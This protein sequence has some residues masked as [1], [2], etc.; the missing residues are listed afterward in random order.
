M[1][2]GMVPSTEPWGTP[3]WIKNGWDTQPS[4]VT[5]SYLRALKATSNND[6]S[7]F[8]TIYLRSV[9]KMQRCLVSQRGVAC[10]FVICSSRQP[11]VVFCH[12]HQACVTT[13]L[14][15]HLWWR[16]PLDLVR[17][18]DNYTY[19]HTHMH[20]YTRTHTDIRTYIHTNVYAYACIYI[21]IDINT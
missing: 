20:P 9:F 13:L 12:H 1:I 14:W 16:F 7:Y 15:R 3:G 4:I 10:M 8:L 11:G 6:T 21:Y 18:L 5:E 2:E 19:T 17:H